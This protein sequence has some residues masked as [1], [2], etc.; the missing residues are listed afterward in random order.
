MKRVE[1]EEAGRKYA[2]MKASDEEGFVDAW[3]LVLRVL[4]HEVW[5]LLRSPKTG[6]SQTLVTKL[7]D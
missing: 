4:R 7:T 2:Y 3:R 1:S 5:V 6:R